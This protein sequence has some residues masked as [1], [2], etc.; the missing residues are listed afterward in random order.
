MVVWNITHSCN[1]ACHHCHLGSRPTRSEG[2]LNTQ[3]AKLFLDDLTG[4]GVSLLSVYGGEPLTRE[5]FLEL[6]RY[7]HQRGL[8]MIVSTNASLLTRQLA[9]EIKKSGIGFVGIDLDGLAQQGNNGIDVLSGLEKALPALR[10]LQDTSMAHSL[11]ITLDES[12][13]KE[14]P[15]IVKA[16][17]QAGVKRLAICHLWEKD[18][19]KKIREQRRQIME[20]IV[21]YT[22][23]HNCIEIVTEHVYADGIY[24]YKQLAKGDSQRAT[25]ACQLL[26]MQ[27][28]CPAGHRLVNVDAVGNI[29]PCPYWQWLT[30]GNIHDEKFSSLWINGHPA[31]D[32]IRNRRKWMKGRCAKCSFLALC[33]G[34]PCRADRVFGNISMSDPIC[35]V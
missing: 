1:L 9:Q 29:H 11:R 27:G 34:C 16:M 33:G 15:E 25:N 26:A 35:Y 18:D 6:A 20:F 10:Y 2:E 30:L 22:I 21:P 32:A 3:E 12:K 8:R 13:I 19:W 14:L 24:I 17:E 31:L 28:G 7:A 23:N 4:L 5:D